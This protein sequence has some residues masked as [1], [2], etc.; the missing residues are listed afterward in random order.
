M[1]KD[2]K[3]VNM[4]EKILLWD[5][6]DALQDRVQHCLTCYK[7]VNSLDEYEVFYEQFEGLINICRLYT[8]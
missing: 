1:K 7:N 8:M 6:S 5:Y 3:L 2:K 4:L